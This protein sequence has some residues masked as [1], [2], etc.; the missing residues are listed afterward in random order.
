[1]AE[2]DDY[3]YLSEKDARAQWVQILR[4]IP[5]G[6]QEKFTPVEVVLSYA[7]FFVMDPHRYGKSTIHRAPEILRL[8]ADLFVRTPS[9]IQLKMLNLDGSRKNA[10]KHEWRFFAEMATNPEM[11][12]SLFGT[13]IAAAREVGIDSRRLPNF[14]HINGIHDFDLLGQEELSG[15]TFNTVVELKAAKKRAELAVSTED[16]TVRIV[17]QT[18]RLGQ[19][20]FA[21]QVLSNYDH[22]CAFCGF[23]PRSIPGNKLLVA[24]HIKPW[25]V[26][27]DSERL[28]PRNGI[29]ACPVHDAAF[30]SGLITVNGGLRVHR[31]P[32]LNRSAAID[33]NVAS[34]FGDSLAN[35]LLVPDGASS[36][37]N[38][39]LQWHKTNIFQKA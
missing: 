12:P 35:V 25:S 23:A 27:T 33:Q 14:L 13:A 2:L 16:E 7:L 30:D 18:I 3:L 5:R 36:P 31:S 37:K 11:F 4:R 1:M 8:I 34:Y 10:G 15:S 26:S 24:S 38:N 39:Y 28:D 19:H 20:R 32:A 21:A 6:R 9:S 17:E 29:A 22:S